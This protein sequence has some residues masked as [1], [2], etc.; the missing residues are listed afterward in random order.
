[1]RVESLLRWLRCR[2]P[3]GIKRITP[4]GS[5]HRGDEPV[6]APRRVP[7]FDQCRSRR[8]R[9]AQLSD[10]VWQNR[11]CGAVSEGRESP[12]EA[13]Q[14]NPLS[15]SERLAHSEVDRLSREGHQG[16]STMP[17]NPAGVQITRP[18][19]AEDRCEQHRFSSDTAGPTPADPGRFRPVSSRP[20]C[21]PSPFWPLERAPA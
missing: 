1:M 3:H 12:V 17:S 11:A 4:S 18:S 13:C 21:L 19:T 14:G 15:C 9:R 2:P 8:V 16:S 10:H 7:H 6:P 20:T 5:I